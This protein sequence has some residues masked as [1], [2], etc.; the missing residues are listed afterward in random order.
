MRKTIKI[1]LFFIICIIISTT[2]VRAEEE[3]CKI[4]LSADKTILKP[5]DE[6]TVTLLM[7][8]ITK[9]T[10]IVQFLGALDYSNEIFDIVFQEDEELKALLEEDCEILYNG[11]Y[12]ED[13]TEEDNPWYLI[14][15]EQQGVSGICGVSMEEPQLES[16]IVGKIKLKVK[17]NASETQAKISLLNTE[18]YDAENIDAESGYTISDSEIKLQVSGNVQQGTSEQGTGTTNN[19]PVN[20]SPQNNS[21]VKNNQTENK[22]NQDVPYTGIE[23]YIPFILMTVIISV[24]AYINYRKYKD[25]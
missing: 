7:G 8:N 12:D 10:G 22:A 25:I 5:G 9:S 21:N 20:S 18:A 1:I 16:Q 19:N 11:E 17:D 2:F 3:A 13:V 6:V 15:L 23:D 14:Y 24:I 4:T